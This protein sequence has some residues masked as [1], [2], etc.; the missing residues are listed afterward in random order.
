MAPAVVVV[1]VNWNSGAYL[2]GCLRALAAQSEPDFRAVVVDNARDA[3]SE[4]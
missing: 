1:I 2:Q 3:G 4:A